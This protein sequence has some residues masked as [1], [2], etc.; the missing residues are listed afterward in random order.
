MLENRDFTLILDKSGSMSTKDK[1]G[2]SRWVEMQETTIAI[3]NKCETFDPDGLTIYTFGSRFKRR[4]NC[5]SNTINNIFKE[6]EPSG[7]TNLASVL[8]DA[9]NNFFTRKKANSL[10]EN[11]EIIIV[12]T[13]GEPDDKKAVVDVII[14]ASK[15]LDLDTELGI[16]FVQIGTDSSARAYLKL[17]DESLQS[18]GAKFDI[19]DTITVDE[20]EDKTLTEVILGAISD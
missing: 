8:Q 10:K 2:K 7:S 15:Q 3:A 4:D 19:V 12:I 14:N 5:L 16:L 1:P 11:G 18:A 17:L 9:V 6:E 13:D 20:M